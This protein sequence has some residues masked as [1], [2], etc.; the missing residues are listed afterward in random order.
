MEQDQKSNH[1]TIN[2]KPASL[3]L[4]LSISFIQ[5]LLLYYLHYTTENSLWPSETPA[6]IYP[7]WTISILTPLILLLSL[8]PDNKIRVITMT[9]A[10]SAVLILLS[11]YIG[12]QAEPFGEFPLDNL[13]IIFSFSIATACF[14]GLMYLQQ[15]ANL[16]PFSYDVLFTY[17]WRNFLVPALAIA[18]TLAFWL[19]LM[20]WAELFKLINIEI[21]STYFKKEWF[22]YPVLSVAF[23]LGISIFRELTSVIDNITRLLQGL[24]KLLVPLI[25]A[26]STL[27]IATLLLTGLDPL[28]KTG[29]GT[30][31][32]LWLSA[33]IIFFVNAVY[34]DG[35]GE[36]PYS[37]LI[38]RLI[39]LGL[40]TLPVISI[41]SFYGLFLRV[42]QYGLSVERCWALLIWLVLTMFSIGYTWGIIKKGAQWPLTLAKVNTFMGLVVLALTLLVNSPLLDFRKISLNNQ[43]SRV[44][45]GKIEL[46]ELDILYIHKNLGRPGYLLFE[47]IKENIGDTDV[48]LS[49]AL[50]HPY[51]RQQRDKPA[52]IDKYWN[53]MIYRPKPFIV[54]EGVKLKDKEI[55]RRGGKFIIYEIDVNDDNQFEYIIIRLDQRYSYVSHLYHKHNGEWQRHIL[56]QRHRNY[57]RDDLIDELTNGDI[58]SA[59]PDFNDFH[60]GDLIFSLE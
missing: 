47:K 39:F 60:V 38:H 20:L 45:S 37:P 2:T 57:A 32:L 25:I 31:L 3:Y 46:K 34:Q 7:L 35:R 19:V 24:I 42:Q 8:T 11:T 9:I 56:N 12:W 50:D 49:Y 17:S 58:S 48:L 10:F 33:I 15:R 22:Y 43:Y 13:T 41:I 16:E 53:E 51:S 52:D 30:M 27:F 44:E 28:W 55:T 40:L 5:G 21:F 59:R 36:P 18:F 14:K 4:L 29:S 54:P 1:L 26:V 23:G 6:L